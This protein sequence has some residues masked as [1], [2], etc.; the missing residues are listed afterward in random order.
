MKRNL[1]T[2]FHP[3][4][5]ISYLLSIID[6]LSYLLDIQHHI[7][8]LWNMSL[9]K[10]CSS[11]DKVMHQGFLLILFCNNLVLIPQQRTW[12]PRDGGGCVREVESFSPRTDAHVTGIALSVGR[13]NHQFYYQ[14]V[15]YHYYHHCTII[16]QI[17]VIHI[18]SNAIN[19]SLFTSTSSS[20]KISSIPCNIIV[21][22]IL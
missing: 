12:Q 1:Q 5:R 21:I 7:S 17:F 15:C 6:Y 20:I 13:F 3:I 22:L 4:M 9:Q 8:S 11:K 14:L 2:L 18:F 10:F 16:Y 19:I